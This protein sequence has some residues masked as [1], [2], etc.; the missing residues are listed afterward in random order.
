LTPLND[1]TATASSEHVSPLPS[2]PASIFLRFSQTQKHTRVVSRSFTGGPPALCVLLVSAMFLVVGCKKK[3]LLKDVVTIDKVQV[4]KNTTVALF[5]NYGSVFVL[6]GRA[7]PRSLWGKV[8]RQASGKSKKEAEKNLDKIKTTSTKTGDQVT[9][10]TTAPNEKDYG[11]ELSVTVPVESHIKVT[12]KKGKVSVLG[13]RGSV[14]VDSDSGDVIVRG[15]K[16]DVRINNKKGN[17]II[18]GVLNGIDVKTGSG[19]VR[20]TLRDGEAFSQDSV[21]RTKNGDI[22]LRIPMNLNAQ[23][24]IRSGSGE[25][26]ANFPLDKKGKGSGVAKL[27]KGGKLFLVEATKGKVSVLRIPMHHHKPYDARGLPPVRG[28]ST[29]DSK[30]GQERLKKELQ[31]KGKRPPTPYNPRW[32]EHH[33]H[34]HGHDHSPGHDHGHDHSHEH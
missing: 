31:E 28:G 20:A 17:I 6:S 10:K 26:S 23:I 11:A 3:E 30:E 12:N 32:P 18:S 5:N 27:G 9:I 4:D 24:S 21:I 29:L 25:T 19:T 22:K 15:M 16:G 1:P 33:E 13:I 2:S 7:L 34:N 14:D 8:V